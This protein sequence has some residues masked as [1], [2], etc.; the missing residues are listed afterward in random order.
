M[1]LFVFMH[2]L[3]FLTLLLCEINQWTRNFAIARN[4]LDL[5]DGPLCL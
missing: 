5:V 3:A 4:S 2:Y 1:E